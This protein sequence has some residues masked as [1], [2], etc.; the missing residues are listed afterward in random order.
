M[1]TSFAFLNMQVKQYLTYYFKYNIV[2][3]QY[4]TGSPYGI[5]IDAITAC[6]I[7]SFLSAINRDT[8]DLYPLLSVAAGKGTTMAARTG[9]PTG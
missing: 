7:L 3:Y 2:K 8:P 5:H 4:I 9:T 6:F 1:T